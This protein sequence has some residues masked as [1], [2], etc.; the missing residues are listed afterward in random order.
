MEKA[1]E[2]EVGRWGLVFVGA[3][4][5]ITMLCLALYLLSISKLSGAEF[6][7]FVIA[8]AIISAVVGFAPEVQEFSVAGNV[9]KLKEMKLEVINA[10]KSLEFTRVEL[11]RSSLRKLIVSGIVGDHSTGERNLEF[12]SV[13]SLA[14]QS[15]SL[16]SLK[17]EILLCVDHYLVFE[18]YRLPWFTPLLDFDSNKENVN[19]MSIIEF[20]RLLARPKIVEGLKGSVGPDKLDAEIDKV[21]GEMNKLEDLRKLVIALSD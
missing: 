15:N 12:W 19:G 21:L 4:V 7:S 3:A 20:S 11:L 17:S 1:I 14:K 9:V 18:K 2:K 13:I 16:P 6:V 10:V 8:F 5:F